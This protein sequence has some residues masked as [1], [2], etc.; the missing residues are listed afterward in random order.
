MKTPLFFAALLLVTI[1]NA[2][3]TFTVNQGVG[4]SFS[5]SSLTV[6]QGDVVHF[7]LS[8][9]HDITQV[10]LDTWNANGTTPL[11]GGFVFSSGSGDYTATTPG[12]I[13]Y[14]CVVHVQSDG[15]KGTITV[16]AITGI[17]DVQNSSEARVYP[18]PARDIIT[19]RA[20]GSSPV[21]EL[22][23]LDL[24][25]KPVKILTKP[26][27]SDNKINIDITSLSSGIY[28]LVAYSANGIESEKILK[29]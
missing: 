11:A 4:N 15:M 24:N 28:F 29:Q 25:G 1:V 6:N 16:N 23:I 5:P 8:S 21:S 14:V 22:R 12:V 2:Q 27:I 20:S 19:Y 26:D 10:S 3:Q 18:N 9:Q 17:N 7:S 13:Y